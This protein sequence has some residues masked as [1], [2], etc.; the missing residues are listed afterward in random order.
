MASV[1]QAVDSGFQVLNCGFLVG[2]TWI[3]IPIVSGLFYLNSHKYRKYQWNNEPLSDIVDLIY[4]QVFAGN[5][6]R[7]TAVRHN[8]TKHITSRYIRLKPTKWHN[9]ISVRL[10]LYGCYGKNAS[11]HC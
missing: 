5:N 10:E 1:F 8:L 9:H 3:P 7:N 11:C 4:L 2:G 6:D